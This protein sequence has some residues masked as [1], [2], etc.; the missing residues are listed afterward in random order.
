MKLISGGDCT[1]ATLMKTA[2]GGF[3]I[4]YLLRSLRKAISSSTSSSSSL[5]SAVLIHSGCILS[6]GV[7]S[8]ASLCL[9]IRHSTGALRS[10]QNHSML[11]MHQPLR[12]LLVV[13]CALIGL[14]VKNGFSQWVHRFQISE[15][16]DRLKRIF[17]QHA[18]VTYWM[19][20]LNMSSSER[21]AY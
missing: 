6:S 21:P 16:R 1:T 14:V 13:L 17:C 7:A 10:S 20:A 4:S 8:I 2:F 18:I 12:A 19:H 5:S 9:L 15:V 11:L 3:T